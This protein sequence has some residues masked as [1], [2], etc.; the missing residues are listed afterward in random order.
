MTLAR[1][2]FGTDQ[3]IGRP[4]RRIDNALVVAR[5]DDLD[6]EPDHFAGCEV[7]AE[8]HPV[9]EAAEIHEEVL[10]DLGQGAQQPDPTQNPGS[11][12]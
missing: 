2:L 7:L 6:N 9:V 12:T 4:A 8:I 5:V 1:D 11:L 10:N 3:E